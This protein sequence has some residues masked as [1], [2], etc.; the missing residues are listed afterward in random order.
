M[1]LGDQEIKS[2]VR[3]PGSDD[4]VEVTFEG[5]HQK[6]TMDKDLLDSLTTE[7][8]GLGNIT[9][10]CNHFF[11]KRFIAELASHDLEYY[12]VD[13]VAMA[14]RVLAHNLREDAIR[15][16]F[17]CSGGDA[18]PL[19]SLLIDNREEDEPEVG[20]GDK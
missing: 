17:S 7:D 6:V 8:K 15:K 18:I 3:I 13:G 14:M 12:V 16:A 2:V 9:D 19:R 5:D 11:A 1:Y 20:L 10:N 4:K